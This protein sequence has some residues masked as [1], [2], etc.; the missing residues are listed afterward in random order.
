V[1]RRLSEFDTETEAR[2][3]TEGVKAA[4][5][6]AFGVNILAVGLGALFVTVFTTVALDVTGILT[7]TVFAIAGW[8]IIPARRRQLIA[9]FETKIGKLNEDLAGLLKAKFEEQLTRYERQLLDVI[10]P[11]DRFLETEKTK[12]DAALTELRAAQSEVTALETRVGETFP[13]AGAT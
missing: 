6:Q 3:I 9:D 8:L 7:A 10:A 4:V 5:T 11:Y 12:L 1:E 13:E 2:Q